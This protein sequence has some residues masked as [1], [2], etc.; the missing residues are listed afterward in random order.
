MGGMLTD[1]QV[2]TVTRAMWEKG[3]EK[4]AKGIFEEKF[5]PDSLIIGATTFRANP[6]IKRAASIPY[7]ASREQ[8]GQQ[9]EWLFG[10]SSISLPCDIAT[11]DEG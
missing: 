3:W 10:T 8:D 11:A 2:V 9:R 4:T 5:Q 7:S 6:R 1:D